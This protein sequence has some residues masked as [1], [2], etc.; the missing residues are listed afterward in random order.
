V[1]GVVGQRRGDD[2]KIALARHR[3][4]RLRGIEPRRDFAF[5]VACARLVVG[6]FVGRVH[7]I[8]LGR[9]HGHA[10]RVGGTRQLA[11]DAAIADDAE[12][13]PAQGHGLE[14]F[15]AVGQPLAL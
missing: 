5:R 10:E 9:Q 4:D 3:A 14:E 15:V 12:R 1:T 13:L 6:F 2:Q 7:D 8:A 11:P